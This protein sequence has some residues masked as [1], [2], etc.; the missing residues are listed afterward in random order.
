MVMALEGIRILDLTRLLPGPYGSL[1]LADLG[2]EVVK[3]EQ[4]GFGDYLRRIN[5]PR[6]SSLNRNKKSITLNLKTDEGREVF[7]RLVKTADA[8][9]EGNR[10][11]VADRLGVGYQQVSLHNPAIIYCSISGFGQD[12]PY[13][14]RPGHDIN[15]MGV[16]G[17]LTLAGSVQEPPPLPIAD[18]SSGMFAAFSIL[19]A[20]IAREKTGRGQYIDVSMTD[21]VISWMGPLF[22]DYQADGKV[23]A[24]TRSGRAHY[25]VFQ[26]SDK[27]YITLGVVEDWFWKNLCRVI[28]RQDM[29]D[30]PRYGDLFSRNLHW[31]DIYPVLEGAF[32]TKS[33]D[34]WLKILNDDDVPCGPVNTIE[35]A[36]RDP[37]V[38]HRCILLGKEGFWG[39][40]FP[41]RLSDTPASTRLK[42]PGLGEHTGPILAELGYSIPQINEL[43]KQ[44][45]V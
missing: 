4:P 1:L 39:A 20:L 17:A 14:D 25:G 11:G 16:A 8:V 7:Y 21:G 37:H 15:Y 26:C 32:K 31:R 6:F 28:G 27:K 13:R 44:G 24:S 34:E 23:P 43:R 5:H 45:I 35:D 9:M 19:A 42:S 2:A 38:L 36:A 33:R 10:P 22:A 41:V 29:A 18:Y 3:V 30:D 12:G 40:G